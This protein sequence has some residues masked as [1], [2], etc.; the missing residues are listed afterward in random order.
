[1]A[2]PCC[3]E[4]G[5]GA[6]RSKRRLLARIFSTSDSS[7]IRCG[8][9]ESQPGSTI[10]LEHAI[11]RL[12]PQARI[13]FVLHDVEGYRHEEIAEQMGL[14]VV[15]RKLNCTG[16]KNP[17][18]GVGTMKCDEVQNRLDEYVD[19]TLAY[20]ESTEVA[21]HMERCGECSALLR[22]LTKLQH[23]VA[24]LPNK[25][26]SGSRFVAGDCQRDWNRSARRANRPT[27]FHRGEP[28]FAVPTCQKPR[29]ELGLCHSCYSCCCGWQLLVCHSPKW[30][31]VECREA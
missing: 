31:C 17:E 20:P 25:I 14:A 9:N 23:E 5:L 30:A 24:S 19:E 4:H 10:D 16:K 27:Q 21:Q 2:A 26:N 29:M 12:P 6:M 7:C 11:A 3:G 15:P 28:G 1:M 8:C 22:S 13:I 18:G